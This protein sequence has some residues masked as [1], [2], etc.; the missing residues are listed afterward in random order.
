[1]LSSSQLPA[2]F[3][4]PRQLE[5]RLDAEKTQSQDET[6]SS[7]TTSIQA[8]MLSPATAWFVRWSMGSRK[9]QHETT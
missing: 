8:L 5:M 7:L 6:W 4:D 1:M 9:V 2:S 3:I